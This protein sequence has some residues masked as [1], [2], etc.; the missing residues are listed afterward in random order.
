[1]A[2]SFEKMDEAALLGDDLLMLHLISAAIFTC[3]PVA[4]YDGD[5]PIICETGEKIRIASISAREIDGTC[6][7][8]HPCPAASGIAALDALVA[9]LGRPTGRWKTGHISVSGPPIRCVASGR[10]YGRIVASCTLP[11]GR[12]LGE[13]MLATGTVV[14]WR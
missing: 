4:V 3:T 14:R 13:A 10:S 11:D 6:R 7:P 9:L 5:G 2:R 1:M 8:G 12:D